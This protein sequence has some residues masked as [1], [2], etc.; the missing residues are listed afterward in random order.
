MEAV[1]PYIW[2]CCKAVDGAAA[3]V[4]D[5]C[6][7]DVVGRVVVVGVLTRVVGVVEGA[8]PPKCVVDVVEG[9]PPPR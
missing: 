9:P 1:P 4:V 6:V 5:K 3:G 2:I 7:V 8:N